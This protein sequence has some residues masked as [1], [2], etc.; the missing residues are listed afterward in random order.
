MIDRYTTKACDLPHNRTK[1]SACLAG[2]PKLLVLTVSSGSFE[3]SSVPV[4][5][6]LWAVAQYIAATCCR[7][8]DADIRRGFE[9]PRKSSPLAGSSF[10]RGLGAKGLFGF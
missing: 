9:I 10:K 3:S 5:L 6:D 2:L 4:H 8:V 7:P 1:I